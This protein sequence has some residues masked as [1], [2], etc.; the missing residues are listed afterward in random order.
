MNLSN[1]SIIYFIYVSFCVWRQLCHSINASYINDN[2]YDVIIVGCGV[3]GL[4]AAEIL[5]EHNR[6]LKILIL[7]AQNHIGG[8]VHTIFD[9]NLNE[10]KNY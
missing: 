1:A 4:K 9:N 7:E 6:R 8:R 3:S 10:L 2:K 5:H